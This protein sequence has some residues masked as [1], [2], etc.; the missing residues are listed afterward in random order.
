[1]RAPQSISAVVASLRHVAC[2]SA[3]EDGPERDET[4]FVAGSSGSGCGT[5]S[6][7]SRPK[8]LR[9]IVEENRRA[10]VQDAL[11]D[12]AGGEDPQLVVMRS[13]LEQQSELIM[14]MKQ[15]THRRTLQ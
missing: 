10:G 13:R 11:R 8:D 14:M 12:S 2:P 4:E 9:D 3:E 6:K 1:M 5:W 15:V 7:M